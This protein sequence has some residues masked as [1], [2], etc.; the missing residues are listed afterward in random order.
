MATAE[1]NNS[2][3]PLV[4]FGTKGMFLSTTGAPEKPKKVASP[5]DPDPDKTIIDNVTVSDWGTGNRFPDTADGI[6]TKVGVLNSGLK[7]IRN[8]TLGQGIYPVRVV[9][10]DDN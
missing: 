9:G 1:Y 3:V 2:G 5:Q 4:A 7:F 6:I 8:F 10:Y